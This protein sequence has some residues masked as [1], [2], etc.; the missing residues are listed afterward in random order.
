MPI[1]NFKTATGRDAYLHM[2]IGPVAEFPDTRGTSNTVVKVGL[3]IDV[4]IGSGDDIWYCFGNQLVV[5]SEDPELCNAK[6]GDQVVLSADKPCYV[7]N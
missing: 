3:P 7:D 4:S 5:N 6:G 2:R 1:V